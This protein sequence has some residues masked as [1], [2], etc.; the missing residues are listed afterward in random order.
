[1]KKK[2]VSYYEILGVPKEAS[3]TDIKKAYRKLALRWHPD[4][5]PDSA[6]EAEEEFKKIGEAYS[7][8]SDPAKKKKYDLYGKEGLEEGWGGFSEASDIFADFFRDFQSMDLSGEEASF[9]RGFKMPVFRGKKRA[10]RQ[11]KGRRGKGLGRE[12]EGLIQGMAGDMAMGGLLMS[13]MGGG[14]KGAEDDEEYEDEGEGRL[15]EGLDG[16]GEGE[17][18]EE[19]FKM[20]SEMP[21]M[22]GMDPGMFKKNSKATKKKETKK[23]EE[24]EEDSEDDWEDDEDD[25]EDDD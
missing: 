20:M 9:L 7:V 15:L 1:M 17:L 14:K 4:K 22:M 23:K 5:N 3:E 10:G 6:K 24:K 25:W 21:D 2:E 13:M 18:Q 8:L 16:M 19:L 12:M 11:G